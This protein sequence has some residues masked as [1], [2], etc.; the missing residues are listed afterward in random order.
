M[1]HTAVIPSE[2]EEPAL[3]FALAVAVA[4]APAVALVFL[5]VISLQGNLLLPYPSF[6]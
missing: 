3:A 4:V 1:K 2:A 5:S 6:P